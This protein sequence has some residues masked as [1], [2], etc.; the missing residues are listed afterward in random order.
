[1]G[2]ENIYKIKI[3]TNPPSLGLYPSE[4]RYSASTVQGLG[5]VHLI[6]AATALLLASL[7]LSSIK[8]DQVHNTTI[9]NNTVLLSST[10]EYTTE[11]ITTTF[12]ETEQTNY[13][14]MVFRKK[15]EVDEYEPRNY[16][17][18]SIGPYLMSCGSLCAGFAALLAWKK[19]YI[20]NNIKWFFIASCISAVTSTICLVLTSII[21]TAAGDFSASQF[22]EEYPEFRNSR[23]GFSLVLAVNILIA[24]VSEVIWSLLSAK[25]AY[26]GMVNGYPDDIVISRSGGK[27]EVST[28]SKGN[29]K[30]KI[31]TP[32]ILNHFPT[33]KKLAKYFPKKDV[34]NLPKAES[35]MEYQERVNKFLSSNNSANSERH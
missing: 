10:T 18:L 15:R 2:I 26:K 12:E 1:M 7:S 16:A 20:D 11:I 22:S 19:W 9:S 5:V 31:S 6:L 25:I 29:K 34:G 27:V 35:N 8:Y 3:K 4:R 21:V 32:D 28:I 30:A 13:T 24:S 14:D 33:S 17:N 23:P